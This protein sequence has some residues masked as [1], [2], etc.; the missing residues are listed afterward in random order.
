MKSHTQVVIIGGGSLGISLLYHLTKEGWT[1]LLLVEKGELTSGSTWHAAGLCSNFIGNMTV[2]KIHDY[3]IRLYNEILP[4]ETGEESSF[5]QT[6]SI[7]IGYSRLEEEWFRN[8]ESRAK[9]VPCEFNI[10]SQAEAQDL[11]P[12]ANFDKARIIVSTPND[13]HVDPTSVAMPL[14]QLAR[15]KGA[16][17]SRFNRVLEINALASGE[18]QVVTEKGTIVAEHV[19]NAAGCFA[20][21]VSALLGISLPI[22]NLEHQYLVTE[23]HPS[24]ENTATELPVLRDSHCSA[25]LRQEANGLLI[26]PYETYGSKPWA[27]D[28]MDWSFDRELFPGDLERLMPFLNRCMDLMPIFSEVGIKT[29]INGP[30]THTPDDNVLAGPQAGLRNFWNLCGSS[31]GIAQGGLGKYMAQWMVHG[32]T[33][34]N[35]ASLDSRRFGAWADR[36]Y[37]ITK[38]IESYEIMY[39]AVGV[40]DNRPH[41]RLKRISPLHA[42]LAEKDAVHNVVQGYEKPLWFKTDLIRSEPPTWQRSQAHAAVADECAA[43]RD[44]AGIIDIS[45][46]AKFEISGPDAAAFLDKLSSNKLP[47]KDGRMV[48]T[49]FHG[50]NGGIVTE[51]SITRINEQLFYLIGPIASENRDLHWMQQHSA[52]LNVKI[53]NCTDHLGGVLL[54]GPNSRAILQ[55]LTNSDLS[56]KAFPWLSCQN[57]KIDSAQVRMLRVSY[58]GELGFELHMPGYQLV[59]LYQSLQRAG[60]DH[61]LRDFGGYAFNS[62]RME[63]AYRA[64]GSEFTEEISGVEA[65]MERFIDTSRE[66]IGVSSI[67]QRLAQTSSIR[68]AYLAFD[69]DIACDCFGNEAIYYQGELVGLTTS[70][71]YGHRVGYSLAF[72]YIKPELITQDLGLQIMTSAGMRSAHVE[73]DAAYDPTNEKLRS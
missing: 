3:S 56:A 72:A 55:Q 16:E 36:D 54:T 71:A 7:R 25:Y 62:L 49:L 27:L 19:V 50:P 66:F 20:P 5:H 40:N 52:D 15:S 2:A 35:M 39:T 26:G 6:G 46:A 58:A 13:G 14:A 41:A 28:G 70:G 67:R 4:E 8:L 31:I 60:V 69:D 68:L 57:V 33:E 64:W 9:N 47:V 11:H 61:G 45:G 43:V 10:I 21:E 51:Q 17:I 53:N 24:L 30:I 59:S 23:N 44:S 32:Q 73:L 37:C 34:L 65:G 29:V 22:V 38:A 18:W 48:L 42:L 63:K 12:W 1:D